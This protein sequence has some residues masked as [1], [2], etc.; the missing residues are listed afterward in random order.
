MEYATWGLWSASVVGLPQDGQLP[1]SVPGVDSGSVSTPGE[2]PGAGTGAAGTGAGA[3]NTPPSLF[4]P[5]FLMLFLVVIFMIFTTTMSGR[6]EKKRVAGMLA[7]LKRGDR[8]QT[9]GGLIGTI[10][11]VRED[12][13]VLRIDDVNGTK[14]HFSRG[15]VQGVLKSAKA[16]SKSEQTTDE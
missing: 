7:S 6:K 9:L 4:N 3:A 5:M 13:F 11:E 10:H 15:A 2:T 8:V 16:D 1:S 14:A 12:S